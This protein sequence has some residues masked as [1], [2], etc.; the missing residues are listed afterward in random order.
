MDRAAA[1]LDLVDERES[2]MAEL[3]SSLVRTPSI[4]GT[5][6]E[7]ELLRELAERLG[8]SGLDLDHW[9]IPLAETLA[10][11]DFPGIEVP[12]TE[13]WGL[14]ARLP[15]TA[16]GPTLMLNAHVD[17]VPP[18]DPSTWTATDPFSGQVRDGRVFGRGACDMKGGLVA[19]LWAVLALRASGLSLR[20]DVVL[21]CVQGEE[22]GGLGT[23]A[24][25]R[26]GW[27]A[28]ACVIPEPTSLDL[29]PATAGALTFRL[30]VPGLATHASRRT[31]GVSAIEK[32]WPLHRALETLE[33]ERNAVVDPLV[34]RW[35]IAYPISIGHVHSGDWASSVPDLLVA[36]GRYGVALGEPVESARAAFESCIAAASSA[37]P[38][39]RDH[40]ASVEWW[41]GQFASGQL[42]AS[43]DL[44]GRVR[45][46]HQRVTGGAGQ[47]VWAAPYGS[48]LR[49]MNGIGGI[50]TLHYGP[51]DAALAHGP[52]ESVPWAEVAT[53]A[54]A[55]ALLA[56][57]FCG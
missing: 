12:R 45:A 18:G 43:S 6:T 21:A 30:R 25:L 26:R 24:T 14:V 9:Q 55:L 50:P 19:A 20:G 44:L 8:V 17:V 11:Q 35:P 16:N 10:A 57:D 36:E 32:L 4:T 13:A 7:N 46:A 1:V 31:E 37:D 38:W 29:V 23:F 53:A 15:G 22:D 48:D 56:L 41:G 49:L 54:Q 33:V 34:R 52:D 42:P 28:D 51:G 47:D 27:T 5:E 2:A 40:P 39:L 3:L